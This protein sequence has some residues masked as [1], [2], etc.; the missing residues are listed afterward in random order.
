LTDVFLGKSTNLL[1]AKDTD[2][3]EGQLFAKAFDYAQRTLSGIGD[4][5]LSSLIRRVLFG[6]QLLKHS[7]Q[8]IHKFV[9]GVFSRH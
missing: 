3:T 8:A 9:D 6:D 5:N 1:S 2:C 4:F 7:L